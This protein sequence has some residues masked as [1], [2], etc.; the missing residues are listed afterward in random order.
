MDAITKFVPAAQG[1]GQA[2]RLRFVEMSD[3]TTALLRAFWPVVAANL[4]AILDAFYDH[5]GAFPELAALI[6]GHRDRLKSAQTKHWAHLFAGRF[7]AEYVASVEAIGHA[8]N[9]IGLEPRWYI[10]GYSFVLQRLLAVAARQK[11]WQAAGSGNLCAAISAAVLLDIDFAISTYQQAMLRERQRRQEI[12]A[13]AI[14]SFDAAMQGALGAVDAAAVELQ[15]TAVTLNQAVGVAAT[16]TEGVIEAAQA[17]T[18]NVHAVASAADQLSASISEIGQQVTQ[19]RNVNQSAVD[20]SQNAENSMQELTGVA[21]KIGHVVKLISDIASQ[22]NL[23]ALNATIEAARAGEAGKGFAVVA[24]EVKNLAGQTG[25]ATEEITT[26]VQAIQDETRRSADIIGRISGTIGR[27]SEVATTIAGAIDEQNAATQEI[28]RNVQEAADRTS[29]VSSLIDGMT[30]ST[31]S[32]RDA[33]E[34]VLTA[35]GELGR[36]A[37]ILRREIETFLKRVADA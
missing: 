21:G 35:S 10:G 1:D 25:R 34:S 12:V 24:S 27:M 19:S 17:A 36:Q 23:L 5:I 29:S 8:H 31:T 11:R 9:R 20:E 2:Q 13:D 6:G 16:Q 18:S 32:T 3:Q 14:A 30:E 26:Q 22:T 28:A 37:Q 4:P 33:A 15:G 7:D